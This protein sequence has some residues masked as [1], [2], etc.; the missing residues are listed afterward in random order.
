MLES[1]GFELLVHHIWGKMFF[2]SAT[3]LLTPRNAVSVKEILKF[4]KKYMHFVYPQV[5]IEI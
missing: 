5:A 3:V 4:L 2:T 1:C